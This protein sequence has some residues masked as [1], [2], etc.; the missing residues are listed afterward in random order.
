MDSVVILEELVAKVSD[1]PADQNPYLA[2]C[3]LSVFDSGEPL[4]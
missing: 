4:I 3:V 1:I 2:L